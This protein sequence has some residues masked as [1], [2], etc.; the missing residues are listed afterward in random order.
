M[1]TLSLSYHP[2]KET[3]HQLYRE[4]G[5][6]A[7]ER[8]A[9]PFAYSNSFVA[10]VFIT[11]ADSRLALQYGGEKE[12]DPLRWAITRKK[13]IDIANGYSFNEDTGKQF[14]RIDKAVLLTLV[15]YYDKAYPEYTKYSAVEPT[16]EESEKKPAPP[17]P[18]AYIVTHSKMLLALVGKIAQEM[19]DLHN[20]SYNSDTSG[21]ALVHLTDASKVFMTISKIVTE[22]G[23]ENEDSQTILKIAENFSCWSVTGKQPNMLP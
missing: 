14:H 23:I 5:R 15:D 6:N 17:T 18:I 19:R 4:Y 3:N 16:L 11:I 8:I 12:K 10:K 2:Y 22:L 21:C 20:D 9:L 1:L 7:I 13:I